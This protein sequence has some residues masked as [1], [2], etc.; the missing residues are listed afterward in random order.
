MIKNIKKRVASNRAD[1]NSVSQIIWIA[2]AAVIAIA[3]GNLLYNAIMDKGEDV[4]NKIKNSDTLFT[5]AQAAR[6]G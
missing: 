1:A 2:L 3:L 4:S 5:N 6:G